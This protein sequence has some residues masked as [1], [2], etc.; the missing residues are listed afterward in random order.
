MYACGSIKYRYDD[1]KGDQNSSHTD[2]HTSTVVHPTA[3]QVGPV[4]TV[5]L[6]GEKMC[7]YILNNVQDSYKGESPGISPQGNFVQAP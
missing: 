6:M 1:C 4:H 3:I 2:C 7:I 5:I